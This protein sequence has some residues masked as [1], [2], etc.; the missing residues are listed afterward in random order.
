MHPRTRLG[1]FAASVVVLHYKQIAIGMAKA[2]VPFKRSLIANAQRRA[3]ARKH[4]G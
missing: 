2:G 3:R 1:L 4:H